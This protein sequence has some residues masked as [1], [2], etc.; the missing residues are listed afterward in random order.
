M[1]KIKQKNKYDV[2]Q[3]SQEQKAVNSPRIEGCRGGI[4][5]NHSLVRSE[6]V[7]DGLS[8]RN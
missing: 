7:K 5:G 2:L 4:R 6:A 3:D 1:G 8:E